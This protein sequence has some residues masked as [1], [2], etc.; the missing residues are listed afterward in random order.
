MPRPAWITI[1]LFTLPEMTDPRHHTQFILVEMGSLELS[2]R[3]SSQSLPQ[4]AD[5]RHEPR[6]PIKTVFFQ[7]V[8]PKTWTLHVKKF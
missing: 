3:Q 7:Q 6:H 4:V 5:Y 2:A 1:F 8:T